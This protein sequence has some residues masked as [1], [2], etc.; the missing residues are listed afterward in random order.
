MHSKTNFIIAL[1]EVKAQFWFRK[2][3]TA[4]FYL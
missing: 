2:K 4:T 1:N 3:E